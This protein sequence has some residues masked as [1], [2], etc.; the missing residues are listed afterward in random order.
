MKRRTFIRRD[1]AEDQVQREARDKQER[2]CEPKG[3]LVRPSEQ[4]TQA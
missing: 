4:G 3:V 1:H 2:K